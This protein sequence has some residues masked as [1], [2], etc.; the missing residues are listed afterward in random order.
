V[1]YGVVGRRRCDHSSVKCD[2]HI[3]TM[4]HDNLINARQ[5]PRIVIVPR[6]TSLL[7]LL[8]LP[9]ARVPAWRVYILVE[10]VICVAQPRSFVGGGGTAYSGQPDA[11]ITQSTNS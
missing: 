1:Q 2:Q 8:H 11:L 6:F 7:V 9:S 5:A 4:K 10:N 3:A